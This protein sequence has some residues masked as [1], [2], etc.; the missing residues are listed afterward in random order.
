TIELMLARIGK[1]I[2]TSQR[3]I[4][5]RV[6]ETVEPELEDAS[7]RL[8]ERAQRAG[9]EIER[10]GRRASAIGREAYSSLRNE[11]RPP[12]LALLGVAAGVGLLIGLS[13]ARVPAART[14]P[15]RVKRT[16]E[17]SK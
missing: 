13:T 8:R 9:S 15:R 5:R 1:L 3:G 7:D 6:S 2:A 4:A 11:I 10:L 12:P 17:R 14:A 16:R